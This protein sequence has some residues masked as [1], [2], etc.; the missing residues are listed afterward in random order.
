MDSSITIHC[1]WGT[2]V[3]I[4]MTADPVRCPGCETTFELTLV[5]RPDDHHA[6]GARRGTHVYR[7]P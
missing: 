1:D 5:E 3:R 7:G 2:D 4:D 6:P